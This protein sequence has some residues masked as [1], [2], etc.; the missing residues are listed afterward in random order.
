ML[1]PAGAIACAPWPGTAAS[2]LLRRRGEG[3]ESRREPTIARQPLRS[4]Q[5]RSVE[6]SRASAARSYIR[7]SREFRGLPTNR[8]RRMARLRVGLRSFTTCDRVMMGNRT[9]LGGSPRQQAPSSRCRLN[10]RCSRL[11]W[12]FASCWGKSGSN[13]AQMAA[14]G[15]TTRCS[16]PCWCGVPH[17]PPNTQAHKKKSYT[18]RRKAGAANRRGT[19]A[20]Q[21]RASATTAGYTPPSSL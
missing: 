4:A 8:S 9:R 7:C 2:T 15:R 19:R 12:R 11:G 21:V 10:A 1:T 16:P 3:I 18:E 20:A 13:R 6:R 5:Q 17:T 14:C